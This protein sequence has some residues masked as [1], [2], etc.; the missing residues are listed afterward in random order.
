VLL[1]D[2]GGPEGTSA[3]SLEG[4]WYDKFTKP[5]RAAFDIVAINERES[6]V[7]C[8][9]PRVN[10]E[11]PLAPEPG[12]FDTLTADNDRYARSCRPDVLLTINSLDRARDMDALRRGLGVDAV[13]FFGVSYGT[14]AGQALAEL[15]PATIRAM[16]L[17]SPQRPRLST[18]D[19]LVSAAAGTE[20]VVHG[21]A[22]WCLAHW[23]ARPR[24][25]SCR[26]LA[27]AIGPGG[28]ITA[29]R[30]I[31]HLR[32][33]AAAAE[34]GK[35]TDD[36]GDLVT[37]DVLTRLFSLFY[38]RKDDSLH[39]EAQADTLARW[40]V[41]H[42]ED[43]A[44]R[45]VDEATEDSHTLLR[46]NDFF[47]R[48]ITTDEQWHGLWQDSRDGAPTVRTSAQHWTWM[49]ACLGTGL[50]RWRPEPFPSAVPL[51]VTSMRYDSTTPWTWAR[52]LATEAVAPLI[53]Y[54]GFG[55]GAYD[56]TITHRTGRDCVAHP[57]EDFLLN[58]IVPTDRRCR[59]AT[60]APGGR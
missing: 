37:P 16:V 44:A 6:Q 34:A 26:N 42:R 29:E 10:A 18:R 58:G 40:R 25:G 50:G 24:H 3:D 27:R 12:V 15:Y 46:C 5:V 1:V 32:E 11:L 54:N 2:A 8:Q 20:E 17:D 60:A 49:R 19:Y 51:L 56:A 57:V 41:A 53:T 33:L 55:H 13:R 43:V 22:R 38:A 36:Q 48:T 23:M 9:G 45:T 52:G 21:F 31:A 47:D 30:V 28:P 4:D 39:L 14:V 59:G 7:R 35:L